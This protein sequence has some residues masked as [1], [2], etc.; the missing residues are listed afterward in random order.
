MAETIAH[1]IIDALVTR[2]ANILRADGY[3]TDAGARVYI[4]RER[5]QTEDL[6]CVVVLAGPISPS[7][8]EQT[9]HGRTWQRTISIQAMSEADP[10][11]PGDVGERLLSD[12]HKAILGAG[13]ETLG[14]LAAGGLEVQTMEVAQ[15]DPGGTVVAAALDMVVTYATDF[16]DLTTT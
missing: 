14:G 1:R 13:D 7:G 3:E 5:V 11:N 2:V 15:V 6:P 10:R 8:A 4:G 12:L 16:D 9:D